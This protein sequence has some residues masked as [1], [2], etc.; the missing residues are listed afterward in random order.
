MANNTAAAID[1]YL[2]KLLPKQGHVEILE[3]RRITT[4]KYLEKS[5][6]ADSDMPLLRTQLIGS[7]AKG[8]MSS[9]PGDIDVLAVFSNEKNIH[10]TFNNAQEMLYKVRNAL[11]DYRIETIGS[12]GQAV[13][14][15]YKDDLHVD[16]A[17]VFYFTDG[18]GYS[19][20]GGDGQWISTNPDAQI[21]W[22]KS[23][24]SV[25]GIR[26]KHIVLLIKQWNSLHGALLSSY[27][28]ETMVATMFAKMGDNYVRE[29]ALF[30][31]KAPAYI[32]VEDPGGHSGDLSQH[33]TFQQYTNFL[34][35][36]KTAE[37]IAKRAAQAEYDGDHKNAIELLGQIFGDK[38]PKYTQPSLMDLWQY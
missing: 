33:L 15:F 34:Q 37:N 19:L 17:P 32:K 13:R 22:Y 1:E 8:T 20:P 10:G 18:T 31:E 28:L 27:H 38:F 11:S 24:E 7:A 9:P 6:G 25:L 12:R 30:F 29:I 21:A 2:N 36:L 3:K 5:F 16:I 14:L 35:R 23:R 4:H 26:L